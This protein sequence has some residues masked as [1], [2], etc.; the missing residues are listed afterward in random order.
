MS[1]EKRN[2]GLIKENMSRDKNLSARQIITL[3]S[4]MVRR[5]SQKNTRC[6][7]G[8]EFVDSRRGKEGITKASENSKMRV[9]RY[10]TIK[11]LSRRLEIQE[12]SG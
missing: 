5:I 9:R 12:F 10:P 3:I 4:A 2:L 8:L 11:N 6:R 1:F 7:T